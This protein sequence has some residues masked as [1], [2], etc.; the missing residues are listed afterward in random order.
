MGAMRW[1]ALTVTCLALASCAE[2]PLEWTEPLA[3]QE[4]P[5][6]PPFYV[7]VLL[8]D[9]PT[10]TVLP[11]DPTATDVPEV[12]LR[13]GSQG[14]WMVVPRL[15]ADE[16]WTKLISMSLWMTIEPET[17]PIPASLASA[18]VKLEPEN[19]GFQTVEL[20]LPVGDPCAVL[21]KTMRVHIQVRGGARHQTVVGR[22]R[23]TWSDTCQ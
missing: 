1:A 18:Q 17:Q 6:S 3:T 5:S 9:P 11:M 8:G 12:P 23:P 2:P 21:G 20:P 16:P 10:L 19:G 14:L 7:G 4:F 15:A 13:L 22:M